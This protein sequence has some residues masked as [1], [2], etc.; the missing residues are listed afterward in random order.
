MPFPFKAFYMTLPRMCELYS[1]ARGDWYRGYKLQ[2]L[3]LPW[4]T[5]RSTTIKISSSQGVRL[6]PSL[7]TTLPQALPSAIH[8][9]FWQW[10]VISY[11]WFWSDDAIGLDSLE[12]RLEHS[13]L[14]LR[15]SLLSFPSDSWENR[16]CFRVSGIGH[17]H[18]RWGW[19]FRTR[20]SSPKL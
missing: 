17:H 15:I 19:H 18:D 6:P 12:L 4:S 3:L 14:N 16:S 1:I 9:I 8:V 11:G 7:T 13:D 10:Q 2:C 5:T 20:I